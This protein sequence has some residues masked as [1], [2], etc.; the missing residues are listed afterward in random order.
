MKI[1]S[2]DVVVDVEEFMAID[3]ACLLLD[4]IIYVL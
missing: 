3:C 1:A 2:G 4:I